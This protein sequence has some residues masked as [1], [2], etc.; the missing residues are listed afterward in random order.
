MINQ[1][2]EDDK[3]SLIKIKKKHDSYIQFAEAI[4][5]CNDCEWNEDI[6]IKRGK[7]I[8]ELTWESLEP[9]LS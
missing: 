6:I 4:S 8:L 1:F 9:W 3:Q 7:R 5:N 2:S